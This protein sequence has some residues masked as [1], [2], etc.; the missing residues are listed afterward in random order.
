MVTRIDLIKW[1]HLQVSGGKG[2]DNVPIWNLLKL[3]AV[4]RV[5]DLTMNSQQDLTVRETDMI[6]NALD[7]MLSSEEDIV[8][9]LDH[10]GKVLGDLRLSEILWWILESGKLKE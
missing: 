3:V 4:R 1:V 8:A 2:M 6:Q 10:E 7:K 9:V 5:K